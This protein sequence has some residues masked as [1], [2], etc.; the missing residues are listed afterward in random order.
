MLGTAKASPVMA[1]RLEPG[2][3]GL[4][5]VRP[6]S[7]PDGCT[8]SAGNPTPLACTNAYLVSCDA[9]LPESEPFCR[10]TPEI[11]PV[12]ESIYPARLP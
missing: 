4:F 9:T 2:G 7:A 1:A 6:P 10:V 5:V 3:R 11:G 8:I 12:R